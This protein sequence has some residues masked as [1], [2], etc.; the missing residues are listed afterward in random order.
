M[1]DNSCYFEPTV[2]L[3]GIPTSSYGCQASGP[4]RI[5]ETGIVQWKAEI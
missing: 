1:R 5:S 2:T 3:N 4:E